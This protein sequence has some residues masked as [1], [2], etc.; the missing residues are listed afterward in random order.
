MLVLNRGLMQALVN[1]SNST[2]KV[3]WRMY[4]LRK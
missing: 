3:K 2:A 4:L 1:H